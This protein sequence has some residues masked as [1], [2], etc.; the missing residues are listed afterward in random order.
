MITFASLVPHPPL[1]IPEIGQEHLVELEKTV[2]AYQ[3]LEHELYV[4]QPET[5]LV[6]T[7]HGDIRDK[8]F[9]INQNPILRTRFKEFGDLVTN[10]NFRSDVAL[11]YK[12]K[13][14]CETSLPLIL[15]ANE[16]IDYGS[17]VPLYYLTKN[18]AQTKVVI[19][20]ISN[21][22]RPEH[23]HFGRVIKKIIDV[24]SE[25]IAVVASGDLSHKLHQD[26]PAGFSVKAQEFD[27]T[28]RRL[29]TAKKV[30]EIINLDESLLREAGECGYR[31]LL[32]LLG[33]I[34]DFNFT[35]EELAYQS[36]FGIGYLTVNFKLE[37]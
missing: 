20:T 8:S 28:I 1:L 2:A 36:P 22:S 17:A 30:E 21:L 5:I 18:L 13:E 16:I 3:A 19:V 37:R 33:I 25:R 7:C 10:L 27:Q 12:I 9:T 11:G 35:A 32:I 34:K 24:S 31:S 15:V 6:I 23:L 29:L 14:S 4:S 26:S